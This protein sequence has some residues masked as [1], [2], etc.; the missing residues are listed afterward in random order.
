MNKHVVVA[1]EPHPFRFDG[2]LLVS[3]PG[4][5]LRGAGPNATK[6]WFTQTKGM[7]YKA[8]LTFAG[9]LSEQA[10]LK[11]SQDGVN[12]SKVVHLASV[13]GLSVGQELTLGWIIT[14]AF[15]AAH[16]MTGVWSAFNGKWQP[17]FRRKIVAID[18][19][20]LT[21]TL[22]V[23]LRY[24]ALVSDGAS[25]RGQ[26]G[27]LQQVGVEHL[28]ITNAG[29][30]AQAWAQTQVAAIGFDHVADGWL[31][32]VHSFV[33]PS[34][35][36][37]GLG[38]G[39]HLLSGGLRIIACNRITV[40]DCHLGK[41][42]NRG[43]GGNGYLFEVRT[44]SEVLMR[45]C[46]GSAGRHNF[47]QNWGFG[48]SGWVLLRCTSSGGF[49]QFA[50]EM[51]VGFLAKSEFHHSLAMA[52]LIDHSTFDDG[53]GAVNRGLQ[54]TGAGHTAT[55]T[56]IWNVGGKGYV[57]SLQ[58]GMGYLIGSLPATHITTALTASGGKGTA[59][60]DYTEGVGLGAQLTPASL[61]DAQLA[62]RLAAKG[63]P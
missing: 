1:K 26:K 62:L 47:I 56:V 23:P 33:S 16:G 21:V 19:S 52:S 6:L 14:P 54:S 46:S 63:T 20:L 18:P 3:H 37:E 58:F 8:H 7:D 35:P 22:D 44:S 45:D 60:Q 30:Y 41:A 34:A 32:D 51:D 11:L 48:T 53:F 10:D 61:F 31:H 29:A 13:Q 38:S 59:P 49:N 2:T 40:S 15:V 50:Q 43:G 57:D 12:R 39:A 55:Q 9:Q 36:S 42:Q 27:Y 17:F 24:A 25:V 28:A 4:T 5:V